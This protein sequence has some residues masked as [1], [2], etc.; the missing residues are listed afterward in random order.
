MT[1]REAQPPDTDRCI[2]L[3]HSLFSQ[4]EEFTPDPALQQKGLDMIINNPQAGRVLVAEE[5]GCGRIAGM[6][7]LLFTVSTALGCRVI[8]L[9]D[10]VVD[11]AMRSVG[12]GS[13]LLH[14]ADAFA[15][16]NGFGRITLLT[17]HDNKAAHE[18]YIRNGYERSDMVV[19]RK[20]ILSCT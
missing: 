3:L 13:L 12:I 4:E 7:V 8:L 1:I 9:E 18:F 2:E 19:F 11:P 16:R 20:R 14:E 15:S 17:D 5:D 10:M 6:L